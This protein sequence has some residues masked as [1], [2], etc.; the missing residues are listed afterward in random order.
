M[1]VAAASKTLPDSSSVDSDP[2]TTFPD[3]NESC[4]VQEKE[5]SGASFQEDHRSS[6]AAAVQREAPLTSSQRPDKE[7]GHRGGS[8]SASRS[9]RRSAE[10]D[11]R[12][13]RE[14]AA[15]ST[16]AWRNE[17]PSRSASPLPA[18]PLPQPACSIASSKALVQRLLKKRRQDAEHQGAFACEV[19]A[20]A[21]ASQL[22]DV[23][24]KHTCGPSPL[25]LE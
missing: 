21:S 19:I 8:A 9:R 15:S 1:K 16:P 3:A 20:C 12:M 2:P 22:L 4:G 24:S 17:S 11:A 5:R 23:L 14:R 25:D 7:K 13:E 10:G 18:A 6:P